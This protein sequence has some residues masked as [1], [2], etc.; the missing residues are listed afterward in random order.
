[1]HAALQAGHGSVNPPHLLGAAAAERPE[2]GL[3]SNACAK[4]RR[5]L[6]PRAPLPGRYEKLR[7]KPEA[8]VSVLERV[9]LRVHELVQQATREAQTASREAEA[10]ARE[11]APP[12]SPSK[13]RRALEAQLREAEARGGGA[14]LRE[15]EVR[16]EQLERELAT[17]NPNPN[18]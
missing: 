5:R 3:R 7:G 17:P 14:R 11:R 8:E 15:A 9:Q 12:E 13:A 6:P 2:R 10:A 18:P 16:V 4:S 1:M